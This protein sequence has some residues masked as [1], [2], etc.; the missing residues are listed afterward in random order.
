MAAVQSTAL[1]QASGAGEYATQVGRQPGADWT[2]RCAVTLRNNNSGPTQNVLTRIMLPAGVAYLGGV[3]F[4]N[5]PTAAST[6]P[7]LVLL[8][9]GGLSLA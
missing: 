1:E 5:N 6:T 7:T 4:A 2:Y 8:P 3:T 9:D